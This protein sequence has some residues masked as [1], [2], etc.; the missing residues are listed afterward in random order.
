MIKDMLFGESY[1]PLIVKA[2]QGDTL[3]F[4]RETEHW[5]YELSNIDFGGTAADRIYTGINPFSTT[6]I[7]KDWDII[8]K[9]ETDQTAENKTDIGLFSRYNTATPHYNLELGIRP[10][11]TYIDVHG[12]LRGKETTYPL[13]SSGKEV[14]IFKRGIEISIYVD[15]TLIWVGALSNATGSDESQEMTV[16]GC[17]MGSTYH[18]LGHLHYFKFRW[19]TKP[20]PQEYD[21]DY[22]YKNLVF[23]GNTSDVI[24]TNITP[25]DSTNINKN[26]KFSFKVS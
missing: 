15:K 18:F 13:G 9:A 21:Y 10:A 14:Q 7:N 8:L 26:W 22:I 24:Q 16:G 19:T 1:N 3:I 5:D 4:E 12:H 20:L 6:N 23:K 25:F 11:A 2:Y 17:T